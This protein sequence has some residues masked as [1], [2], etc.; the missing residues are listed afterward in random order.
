MHSAPLLT[1]ADTKSVLCGYLLRN[2]SPDQKTT[3]SSVQEFGV[4]Q[5][6][7]GI[8]ESMEMTIEKLR[9]SPIGPT[10]ISLETPM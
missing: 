5:R 7:R 4:S 3:K 2:P 10:A 1:R 8:A 6:E 9:S